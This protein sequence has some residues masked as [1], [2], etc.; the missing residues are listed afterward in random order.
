LSRLVALISSG[1][2]NQRTCELAIRGLTNIAKHP[3]GKKNLMSFEQELAVVASSSASLSS[4][5]VKLLM[6]LNS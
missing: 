4:L 2:K 5:V 6:E 1:V 3:I